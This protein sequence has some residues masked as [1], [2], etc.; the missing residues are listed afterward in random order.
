MDLSRPNTAFRKHVLPLAVSAA[1]S[2]TG[3]ATAQTLEEVVVTATKRQES[4]MDVPLA[5][6]ALSGNFIA[7]TNLDDVK[8]LISYTPGV[9]GNSQDSYI[10]AVSVRDRREVAAVRKMLGATL[11]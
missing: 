2:T 4:V 3:V 5:I 8:D 10:D 11:R 1:I 6:T 7:D 9:S